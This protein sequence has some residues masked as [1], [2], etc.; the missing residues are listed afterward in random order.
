M[1]HQKSS[2]AGFYNVN[3]GHAHGDRHTCVPACSHVAHQELRCTV[4]AH[5]GR[6]LHLPAANT[7]M[8]LSHSHVMLCSKPP[9]AGRLFDWTGKLRR[10]CR[11]QKRRACPRG[12]CKSVV[13]ACVGCSQKHNCNTLVACEPMLGRAC[14]RQVLSFDQHVLLPRAMALHSYQL[15]SRVPPDTVLFGSDALPFIEARMSIKA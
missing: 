7:D 5:A 9:K 4:V 3:S 13:W 2:A 10:F 11:L 14:A 12:Q 1:R 15:L 8:F 6:D